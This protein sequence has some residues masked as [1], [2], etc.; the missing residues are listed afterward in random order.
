MAYGFGSTP[1]TSDLL[2]DK[3]MD[4]YVAAGD[5]Y[6]DGKHQATQVAKGTQTDYKHI[7]SGLT[8]GGKPVVQPIK[9][10]EPVAAPEADDADG[11]FFPATTIDPPVDINAAYSNHIE[12]GKAIEAG[13]ITL[14]QALTHSSVA[15][16]KFSGSRKKYLEKVASGSIV[17]DTRTNGPST[18]LKDGTVVTKTKQELLDDITSAPSAQARADAERVA[19]ETLEL[20]GFSEADFAA[21]T[22]VANNSGG[23]YQNP[24]YA[25]KSNLDHVQAL[26]PENYETLLDNTTLDIGGKLNAREDYV[27]GKV[28]TGEMTEADAAEYIAAQYVADERQDGSQRF[29]DFTPAAEPSNQHGVVVESLSAQ[30]LVDSLTNGD[31]NLSAAIN[32]AERQGLG[33]SFI[34]QLTSI[35]D[36]A[37][38]FSRPADTA[39][40]GDG[41][42]PA[43][44]VSFDTETETPTEL[45]V[46][47]T[48][49]EDAPGMGGDSGSA[50]HIDGNEYT[51]L[52]KDS[53]GREVVEDSDGAKYIFNPDSYHLVPVPSFGE[54]PVDGLLGIDPGPA[55]IVSF[56]PEQNPGGYQ[57]HILPVQGI[58]DDEVV[59]PHGPRIHPITGEAGK[60]HKGIDISGGPAV[61][62]APVLATMEGEIVHVAYDYDEER[63][64]GYGHHI[65]IR[66]PN[67]QHGVY[68][69]LQDKGDVEEGDFVVQ[70]Q[71]I[72]RL[73]NSGG[74]TGPHLDWE[75]R[76]GGGN[77]ESGL[78]DEMFGTP[79]DP[80]TEIPS[81][82]DGEPGV[83]EALGGGLSLTLDGLDTATFEPDAELAADI[84]RMKSGLAS[85]DVIIEKLALRDDL[86][87]A[88]LARATAAVINSAENNGIVQA[89]QADRMRSTY[90]HLRA[91]RLGS[92]AHKASYTVSMPPPSSEGVFNDSV[93]VHPSSDPEK[94][95]VTSGTSMDSLGFGASVA[96]KA[97]Q[98]LEQMIQSLYSG[99]IS[100]E[101]AASIARA[102]SNNEYQGTYKMDDGLLGISESGKFEVT[103][104]MLRDIQNAAG[105]EITHLGYARATSNS[106]QDLFAGTKYEGD[107]DALSAMPRTF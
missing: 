73:G 38:V 44:L 34:D 68:S 103:D 10:K 99:R 12:L 60:L 21:V 80:A 50:V 63:G 45:E 54:D 41:A 32:E 40:S 4:D 24:T 105:Q 14:E 90:G 16:S 5:Y 39:E 93:V 30:G 78:Y 69:H 49:E 36:D 37:Y 1:S 20:R 56:D 42:T 8:S 64:T 55:T 87:E 15:H 62:G 74:S 3:S 18:T 31:I 77:M 43:E 81:L 67:G 71:Q 85:P 65:V 33:E 29:T 100:A 97:G 23:S 79:I 51:L 101:K 70:R 7:H 25:A 83:A 94:L 91:E 28:A 96:V 61:L 22:T 72:G 9:V 59:S 19:L 11:G 66:H 57:G 95:T 27:A 102:I 48:H 46:D 26:P 86:D 17:A 104:D 75:L 82:F 53:L 13:E 47:I 92:G 106:V 107:H 6:V 76:E 84:S 89:V 58:D 98:G 35:G 2:G 52:G 88:T